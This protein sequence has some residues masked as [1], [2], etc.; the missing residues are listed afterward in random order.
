MTDLFHLSLQQLVMRLTMVPVLVAGIIGLIRF[1]Q[2][3]LNLR[4]LTAL[5]GFIL[6]MNVLAFAFMIQHRNNMFLMPVYMV[7]EFTLLAL[8][9]RH[10]LQSPTFTRAVPWLVGGFA[11]YVLFDSLA[12]G[13][14]AQFRPGQ[15]VVQGTLVLGLVGLYFRKLL[16]EL[17]VLQLRREPMFWVSAGLLIYYL[18]YLQIAIFSNYLLHYSHQLNANVWMIHS[19]LFIMLYSCYSLALWLPRRK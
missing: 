16:R 2:L 18:G 6:P 13:A 4:Y 10:T 17:R 19:F 14:L 12:P 1:R 8:V 11:A 15:Q 3:P 7:G 9:F 5:V